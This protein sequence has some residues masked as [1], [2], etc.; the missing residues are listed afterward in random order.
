MA[1][2]R[3]VLRNAP[4]ALWRLIGQRITH[5]AAHRLGRGPEQPGPA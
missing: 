4:H 1:A 2:L 3:E 5:V